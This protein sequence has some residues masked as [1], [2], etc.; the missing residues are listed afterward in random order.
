MDAQE[1]KSI[2]NMSELFKKQLI[3]RA[4]K[5]GIY[6]NFGQKEVRKLTDMIG[7]NLYTAP[8]KVR[9]ILF[10]FNDWCMNYTG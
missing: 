5:S 3:R 10:S 2:K 8:Q 9:N 6:E 7:P 1:I 4:E